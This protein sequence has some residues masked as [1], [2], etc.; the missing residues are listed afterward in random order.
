[1][2]RKRWGPDGRRLPCIIRDGGRLPYAS[3]MGETRQANSP[4][5]SGCEGQLHRRIPEAAAGGD[6]ATAPAALWRRRG[7]G[8]PKPW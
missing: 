5:Q 2:D 1:M 4:H 7:R 3:C 8:P 6:Y